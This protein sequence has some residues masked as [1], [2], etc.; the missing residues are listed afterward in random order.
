MSAVAQPLLRSDKLP[1]ELISLIIYYAQ[2]AWHNE[3][4]AAQAPYT[5]VKRYRL[6]SETGSQSVPPSISPCCNGMHWDYGR[7]ICIRSDSG[8]ALPPHLPSPAHSASLVSRKL[9]DAL[10]DESRIWKLDNTLYPAIAKLSG[11]HRTT[12]SGRQVIQYGSRS[13]IA[14]DVCTCFLLSV[15]AF[16]TSLER[17]KL[18]LPWS[19]DGTLGSE[20]QQ[21]LR[22]T[23][24]GADSCLRHVD[25]EALDADPLHIEEDLRRRMTA[26]ESTGLLTSRASC[27]LFYY[28]RT[29]TSLYLHQGPGASTVFG[30]SLSTSLTACS[31]TLEF[32]TID[33]AAGFVAEVQGSVTFPRLRYFRLCTHRICGAG[34]LR[35][36]V[37]PYAVDLHLEPV[38]YWRKS[39]T[40]KHPTIYEVPFWPSRYAPEERFEGEWRWIQ[41]FAKTLDQPHRTAAIH[42]ATPDHHLTFGDPADVLSRRSAT[43]VGLDVRIDP[44]TKPHEPAAAKFPELV[45]LT[46][47]ESAAELR[48][49]LQDP[50]GRDWER[51]QE[52]EGKTA[53]RRSLTFRDGQFSGY[54]R[55]RDFNSQYPK[56]LYDTLYY[57]IRAPVSWAIAAQELVLARDSWLPDRSLGYQHILVNFNSIRAL[58]VDSP[59]LPPGVE[60]KQNLEGCFTADHLQALALSLNIPTSDGSYMCSVLEHI[61]LRVPEET[62]MSW[63]VPSEWDAMLNSAS[64]L[65]SRARRIRLSAVQGQ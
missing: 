10:L 29:L 61:H 9:R 39:F 54:D 31:G 38:V 11:E 26:I 25:V 22:D 36:M 45:S 46:L 28:S 55:A 51:S 20:L 15:R 57:V 65:A 34:L 13:L 50:V 44:S 27:K 60:F 48:P 49:V 3:H 6:V 63:V 40:A 8:K 21:F 56:A 30:A 4:F 16:Y 32:L 37:L 41:K 62:V 47:A 58:H 18:R 52:L 33:I 19:G 1:A 14:L 35:W 42:S 17:V 43:V 2:I 24:G 12:S 5:G 23:R 7:P 53:A 59:A 64:R